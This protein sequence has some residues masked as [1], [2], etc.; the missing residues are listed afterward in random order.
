M[1]TLGLHLTYAEVHKK[2]TTYGPSRWIASWI[3]SM[4]YPCGPRLT[5]IDEFDQRSK[6][7]F[8]TLNGRKC[9]QFLLSVV[10]APHILHSLTFLS[11]PYQLDGFVLVWWRSQHILEGQKYGGSSILC[12]LFRVP[13][14]WKSKQKRLCMRLR[15][16]YCFSSQAKPNTWME[17][18][19]N[20]SKCIIWGTF[21]PYNTVKID[22]VPSI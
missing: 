17:F 16:K 3:R 20:L 10:W 13:V 18:R 1:E 4:D 15:T 9:G 8:G 7:I 2:C 21:N 12:S 14:V 6:Q 19:K 22:T 5:S 11:I